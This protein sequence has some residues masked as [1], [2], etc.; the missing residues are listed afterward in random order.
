MK[1]V[2]TMKGEN[3]GVAIL[4]ETPMQVVK[5]NAIAPP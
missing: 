1:A 3:Q 4:M 5:D 2:A